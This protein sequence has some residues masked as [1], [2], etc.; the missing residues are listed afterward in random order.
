LCVV[1]VTLGCGT[2]SDV[3]RGWRGDVDG[4]EPP[5]ASGGRGSDDSGG[6][7]GVGGVPTTGGS[8]GIG[9]AGTAG[10]GGIG[11]GGIGA[12][13][14][15]AGAGGEGAEEPPPGCDEVADVFYLVSGGGDLYTF[16]P[17][18]LRTTSLGRLR[19]PG[20]TSL[21]SM[22]VA[23]TGEAYASSTDGRLYAIDTERVTC[24]EL[25]FDRSQLD[26]TDFGMGYAADETPS[27]ESLFIVE[28]TDSVSTRI[29]R[30]N[31]RSRRVSPVGELPDR[32]PPLELTGTGDGRLLAFQVGTSSSP[33]RV[34]E[35]S[36]E[37]AAI[38]AAYTID[39]PRGYRAFHFANWDGGLYLFLAL[40]GEERTRVYRFEFGD[41]RT[42]LLG[43]IAPIVVGAGVSTC[44]PL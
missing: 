20:V 25:S 39:I 33:A 23:R 1:S 15:G 5:N 4:N 2:R 19:C 27:G 6:F 34:L 9:G 29:S 37:D 14:I 7:P 31:P 3:F 24:R 12:G 17:G 43:S 30:L 32:T 35:L 41:R 42:R 38:G 22:A 28:Q 10:A 36:R 21:N 11:A 26:G 8:S 13:G 44:A 18:S 40:S 16:E